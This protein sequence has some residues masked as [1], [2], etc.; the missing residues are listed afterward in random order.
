MN[1]TMIAGHLGADPETRFTAN[2]GKVTSMRVATNNRKGNED[3]TIWWRVTL[4]G[5]RFDKVIPHFKK[6]SSIIA[7]GTLQKPEIYT[8]RDG[9]SQVTLELWADTIQFSPFGRGDRAG[10]EQGQ[11]SSFGG[12]AP[13]QQQPFGEQTFTAPSGNDFASVGQSIEHEESMPF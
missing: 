11:Q 9:Q 8:N 13:K 5:D 1:H 3:I 2:G 4:W 6:G 10:Q 12:S 7:M